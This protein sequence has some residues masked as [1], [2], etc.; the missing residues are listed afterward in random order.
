MSQTHVINPTP[1]DDLYALLGLFIDGRVQAN[2]FC[3]M[4]RPLLSQAA[5]RS[6]L[7]DQELR[8]FTKLCQ[9]T[10]RYAGQSVLPVQFPGDFGG[11]DYV[12]LQAAAI[13]CRDALA[14]LDASSGL[15]PPSS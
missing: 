9:A 3:R 8:E 7:D 15:P 12:E 4:F 6:L 10:D 1:R 11:G 14:G 5:S 13:D 2:H